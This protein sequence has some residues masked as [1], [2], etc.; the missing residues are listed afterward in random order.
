MS[1]T[2]VYSNIVALRTLESLRRT[3]LSLGDSL[4]RLSTG[5]RI[6]HVSDDAAGYSIA[7]GLEARRRSLSQALSNVHTARNVLA[8]AEGG[9]RAISDILM[10][11]TEK[12]V[13]AADDSYNVSQRLAIQG[14]IDALS[15]EIDDIVAETSFQGTRL[16]D[17]SF[18]N[19]VFQTGAGSG[20]ILEVSLGSAGSIDLFG[21]GGTVTITAGDNDRLAFRENGNELIATVAPGTY[22]LSQLAA[23]VEAALDAASV[24]PGVNFS[25]SYDDPSGLF[26][27][28]KFGSPVTVILKW[29]DGISANLAPE[30][31]FNTNSDDTLNGQASTTSDFS[32]ITAALSVLNASEATES[33]QIIND[34]INALNQIA[35]NVGEYMLRL[36]SKSDT[37][38]SATSNTEAARSRIEDVDFAQ[39][40]SRRI[41]LQIIQQTAFASLALA[42]AAPELVLT[43]F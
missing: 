7:R 27:I 36:E 14:Q 33:L 23:A 18:S 29:T 35:Q 34:A 28:T 24:T 43:L 19:K 3:H 2:R 26:T 31:G 9:Y 22:T 30:L 39:E 10:I 25:V 16:I 20:D 37:L 4:Y 32:A 13:Q 12:I 41:R 17:G 21:V 40:V 42:N 8:I 15:Q 5:R 1:I 6:N 38:A 11:M